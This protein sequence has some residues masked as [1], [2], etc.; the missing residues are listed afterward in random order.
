MSLTYNSTLKTARMQLVADLISSKTAASSTGSALAGTLEIGTNSGGVFG[1][2]LATITL[3][4]TAGT[5]SGNDFNI[6]GTPLSATASNNGTAAWARIKNNGGTVV[7][8]TLS[9]GTSGTD[10][11]I[12]STSITT[13]QTV[14]MSSGQITHG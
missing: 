7:V 6:S 12:N 4:A 13:G 8:D 14:T 2:V 10:I 1:T 5:V 3:N 9:V 11:I